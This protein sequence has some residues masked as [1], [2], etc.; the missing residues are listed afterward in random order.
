M[1]CTGN[2]Q[3]CTGKCPTIKDLL[4]LPQLWSVLPDIRIGEKHNDLN[5]E[6]TSIIHTNTKCSQMILISTSFSRSSGTI[7]IEGT[8]YF[9]CSEIYQ[10]LVSISE[11]I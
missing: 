11:T 9:L 10:V 3:E 2:V 5:L 6:P 4:Y 7:Q 8:V 1:Q